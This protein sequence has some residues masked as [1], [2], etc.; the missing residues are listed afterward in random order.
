MKIL[1]SSS[2]G[3]VWVE[4]LAEVLS[5]GVEVFDARENVLEAAPV[6]FAIDSFDDPDGV[7][8]RHCDKY[9]I[10]IYTKKMFSLEIIKDLNSTYGDRF[11]R[12]LG[13]DQIS[14]VV[15][16]LRDNQWAKSAF[17]SLVVPNDPGPRIP[18]LSAVQFAIRDDVLKMYCT[19]RS[20]NV[21]NA[22]GNFFGVRALQ[23]D[24][25]GRLGLSLG[26]ISFFVN[27]PHI[28]LSNIE[29]AAAIVQSVRE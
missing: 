6:V 24:V 13:V 2:I 9:I 20:Q 19:F 23:A 5:S 21:F 26:P 10:E 11:F 12:N 28:Y 3:A 7:I 17:I 8:E 18:C 27:F 25:A 29:A 22:Y 15:E 16:R 4:Y 14:W 1:N